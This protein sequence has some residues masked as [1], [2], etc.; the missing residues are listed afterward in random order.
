LVRALLVLPI[1]TIIKTVYLK[2]F[3][4]T[5]P[6][7]AVRIKPKPFSKT[8]WTTPKKLPSK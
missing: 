7:K 1:K 2:S 5:N 4:K 3:L 8:K 6:S